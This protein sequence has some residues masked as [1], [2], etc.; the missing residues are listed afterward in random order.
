[1]QIIPIY[2]RATRALGDVILGALE[3]HPLFVSAALPNRVYAPMFN[4]YGEG[5]H[6]RNH[7]DGAIRSAFSRR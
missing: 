6:F 2:H 1:M 3:R 7:A 4:R 5:M